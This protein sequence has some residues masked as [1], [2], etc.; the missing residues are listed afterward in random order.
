MEE[1]YADKLEIF[2]CTTPLSGKLFS[3]SL[4]LVVC[5]ADLQRSPLG[6]HHFFIQTLGVFK[7]L[8]ANMLCIIDYCSDF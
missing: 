7:L 8:K 6:S 2:L 3:L 4:S 5:H 1:N